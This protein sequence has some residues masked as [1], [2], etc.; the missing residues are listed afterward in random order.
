MWEKEGEEKNK[1]KNSEKFILSGPCIDLFGKLNRCDRVMPL[2]FLITELA[3]LHYFDSVPHTFLYY[4]S[5]LCKYLR[6]TVMDSSKMIAS[7]DEAD[8]A[9]V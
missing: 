6:L 8:F 3:R 7:N 9:K 4:L 1:A 2:L 5:K